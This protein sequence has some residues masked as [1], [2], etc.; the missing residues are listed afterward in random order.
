MPHMKFYM[1]LRRDKHPDCRS[2]QKATSQN[3]VSQITKS[4]NL[5]VFHRCPFFP[6]LRSIRFAEA[7]VA[8]KAARVAAE[9]QQKL[10]SSS[11]QVKL[12][13]VVCSHQM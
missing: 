6:V 7:A 13:E 9:L 2:S 5:T 10:D 3:P 1:F 8:E 11:L 4:N 12:I